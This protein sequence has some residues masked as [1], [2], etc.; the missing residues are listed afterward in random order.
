MYSSGA[1]LRI[2]NL[3]L[4]VAN[5]KYPLVIEPNM[6]A[7]Y[8][9]ARQN[10]DVKIFASNTATDYFTIPTTGMSMESDIVF[11]GTI[12]CSATAANTIVEYMIWYVKI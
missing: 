12:W 11:N 2:G 8:V 4:I 1:N 10:R 5:Q 9:Q 3:A 6:R 7:L